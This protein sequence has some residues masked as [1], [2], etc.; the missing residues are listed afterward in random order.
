MHRKR[1]LSGVRNA[2]QTNLHPRLAPEASQ[3]LIRKVRSQI[4]RGTLAMRAVRTVVEYL[5]FGVRQLLNHCF[6]LSGLGAWVEAAV[7]NQ[8]WGRNLVKAVMVKIVG[9]GSGFLRHLQ[10]GPRV[11][12]GQFL[13]ILR[14]VL[15]RKSLAQFGVQGFRAVG[16][17][18]KEFT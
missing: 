10:P 11:R 13:P 4:S 5:H 15:A 6:Q 16:E 17:R 18:F 12:R 8:S 7:D 9:R 3:E 1:Q 14:T 2:E